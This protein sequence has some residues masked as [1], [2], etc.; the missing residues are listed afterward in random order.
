MVGSV[1]GC[2]TRSSHQASSVVQYLYPDKTEPVETPS[3]PVLSVPMK[4]GI[5]FVPE[6]GETRYGSFAHPTF[7]EKAKMAL[8]AEMSTQF[9]Q[10]PFIKSIELIPTAYLRPKGGF[11]NLDQIRTMFGVDVIALVSYDQLQFTDNG[12]LSL[13]Y[14]TLVGAYVVRGEKNDS[15]TMMDAAVYDIRSRKLLFRAPGIS[16][17]KGSATPVNLSQQLR[18]NS[19]AGFNEAAQMMAANLKEEL[20]KFKEKVKNSPEEFK[21]VPTRG[22]AGGARGGGSVDTMMVVMLDQPGGVSRMDTK[23][24]QPVGHVPLWTLVL[25]IGGLLVY[26]IPGLSAHLQYDRTAILTGEWWRVVTGNWVHFSASHL[27]YDLTALGLVGWMTEWSGYPNFGLLV[28]LSAL[29]IGMTLLVAQPDIQFYGGLSGIATGAIVYYALW[30]LQEGGPWRWICGTVLLFSVGKIILETVSGKMLLATAGSVP[31]VPVPLS[32]LTGG[33]IACVAWL[34]T[35]DRIRPVKGL[36][37]VA[38]PGS[39]K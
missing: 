22:Y 35:R 26:I 18:Q 13:S 28:M 34:C 9:K 15:N 2:A 3:V 12:F 11:T 4:V 33:L 17:I 39:P 31:F 1:A 32:H 19:E 36:T 37:G 14:W 23:T 16:Q 25:V 30:G 38:V 29:G 10:Y 7:S 20:E 5:A 6:G 8:M 21:V 27:S 24:P